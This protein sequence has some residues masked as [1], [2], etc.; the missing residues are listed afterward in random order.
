MSSVSRNAFNS[1]IVSALLGLTMVGIYNNYFYIINAVSS[2]LLVFTSAIA[3]GVGK[4][5]ASVSPDKNLRDMRIINFWYMWISAWCMSCLVG[6]YQP[7]MKLWLGEKFL[8]KDYVMI[9][10]ALYFFLQK[11]GDIQAQYFD[12]A[13]LWW[14][15]F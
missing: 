14:H 11:I 5:I 6:L 15:R 7:F 8:L 10:F 2:F 9:A 4:S 12:G 13:G 3:A 1:I